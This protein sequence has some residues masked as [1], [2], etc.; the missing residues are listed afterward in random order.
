[1]KMTTNKNRF[2]FKALLHFLLEG[3][4][5]ITL[6]KYIKKFSAQMSKKNWKLSDLDIPNSVLIYELKY[7]IENS[8]LG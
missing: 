8:Y 7:Y 5:Q 1:M 6:I 3:C 4:V 2:Y